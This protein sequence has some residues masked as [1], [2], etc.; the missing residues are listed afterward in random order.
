LKESPLDMPVHV[1]RRAGRTI[2]RNSG[3]I[4]AKQASERMARSSAAR[5]RLS[6]DLR[7]ASTA[8]LRALEAE[9]WAEPEVAPS[10]A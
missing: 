7:F 8:R 9:S 6:R 10:A 5:L 4:G 1:A 2:L 3:E